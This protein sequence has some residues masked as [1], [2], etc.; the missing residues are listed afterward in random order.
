MKIEKICKVCNK[1]FYVILSRKNA[2]KYCSRKCLW[3]NNK[4]KHRS[5]ETKRKISEGQKGPKGYQWKGGKTKHYQG[6]V[7]VKKH[8]HP[9]SD[10]QNYVFEHRLIIEI[11]IRRYLK[12]EE[13]IHHI[14][15]IK[16]DNRIEN[17]KLFSNKSEHQKFHN[18]KGS[19]FGANKHLKPTA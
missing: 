1:V 17:L 12:P 14:N 3:K 4:G 11:H 7:L 19:L 6:Y 15:G 9:F 5:E 8:G 10:T 16:D 18:P 13:R 2:A